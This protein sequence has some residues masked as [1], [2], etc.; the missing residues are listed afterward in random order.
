MIQTLAKQNTVFCWKLKC[1]FMLRFG[2]TVSNCTSA[3][4]KKTLPNRIMSNSIMI[5]YS[6]LSLMKQMQKI[7]KGA[8]KIAQ[9]LFNPLHQERI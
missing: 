4:S 9:N 6:S 1:Y 5:I 7:E 2:L 8:W 3:L